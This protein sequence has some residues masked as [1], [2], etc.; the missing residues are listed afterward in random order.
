MTYATP[1]IALARSTPSLSSD[2]IPTLP[3]S[4]RA[5][6]N[7]QAIRET[8]RTVFIPRLAFW[9]VTLDNGI[10]LSYQ[11]FM[12]NRGAFGMQAFLA[13]ASALV[14]YLPYWFV[15]KLVEHLEVDPER[16]HVDLGVGYAIGL[17]AATLTVYIGTPSVSQ[18]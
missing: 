1:V 8:T 17:F 16:K 7:F 4:V 3:A 12:R 18:S 5:I 10:E 13:V 2:D 14:Y 6:P 15:K 11:L 9:T